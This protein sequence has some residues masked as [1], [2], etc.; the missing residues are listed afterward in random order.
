[1]TQIPGGPLRFSVKG[2]EIEGGGAAG[3]QSAIQKNPFGVDFQYEWEPQ[4]SRYHLQWLNVPAFLLD[5]TPV[6]QQAFAK[7]LAK[8]P[9]ALAKDRYHYLMNWDW[10]NKSSPKPFPGNETLPVTYIGMDEALAI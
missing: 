1:M 6:T 4:P 8:N 10:S 7:Y 3:D 2:I 5:T 9:S